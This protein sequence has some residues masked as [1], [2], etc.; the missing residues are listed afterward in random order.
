[1]ASLPPNTTA[2]E[3]TTVMGAIGSGIVSVAEGMIIAD[4]PF[5]GTPI[6]KQIWEALFNWIAGYFQKAAETGA[7]FTVIDT[8]VGSET[9]GI[10]SAL[11]A[12]VAAEKTGDAAQITAA[13][14]AYAKAQSSLVHDD[15][16]G[17]PS[18]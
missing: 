16:V 2:T 18:S 17:A 12:L 7:T 11:A 1:M 8:Q 10:S 5:L 9:S 4:V 13:I 14:Q 15:G 6:I 3:V